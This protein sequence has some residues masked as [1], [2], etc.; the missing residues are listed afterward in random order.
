[1]LARFCI[2]EQCLPDGFRHPFA[3]TML[4]HFAKL[5]ANLRA[6]SR[7][8]TLENQEY[9]FCRLGWRQ[10]KAK[11]LW[12]FWGDDEYVTAGQRK[13][14]DAVEP[15]DEWEELALL[16]GH[17]FLL[18]ARTDDAAQPAQAQPREDWHYKKLE[19][20][21]E[22]VPSA[23]DETN[24]RR[25]GAMFSDGRKAI[26]HGGYGEQSRLDDCDVYS[27]DGAYE[28]KLETGPGNA[29]ALMCHTITS[30]A[31][32]GD[33]FLLA[34]GRQSPGKAIANTWLITSSGHCESANS[35]NDS[36]IFQGRY[37]HSA[38]P[39][40]INGEKDSPG[41]LI[42]GGKS[43]ATTVLGDFVLFDLKKRSW[44]RVPCSS[45]P[46]NRPGPPPR[47]G[48]SMCGAKTLDGSQFGILMGGIS[49][50]GT[51][52]DDVW[53]WTLVWEDGSPRIICRDKAVE[54][55]RFNR[56]LPYARFGAQLIPSV[57]R[58]FLLVGGVTKDRILLW[59]EE[60]LLLPPT[61]RTDFRQVQMQWPPDPRPLFIGMGAVQVQDKTILAGGGAVCFSMGC[62]WN[63][64]SYI[65]QAKHVGDESLDEP[66]FED[67]AGSEAAEA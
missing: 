50:N 40:S 4:N 31:P 8:P 23:G 16:G 36:N 22:P 13:E 6:C 24:Y 26:F 15:F 52:L 32:D 54:I 29:G 59:N 30:V 49:E 67:P 5:H 14:L 65:L 33:L 17:Y 1:M 25:Y 20:T 43:D 12:E 9:R 34:G 19:V 58:S 18:V 62:Y 28:S 39:I 37:R 55:R 56:C 45:A 10:A 2:L 66:A 64:K 35:F 7:Y 60:I 27:G 48:A 47:F 44:F 21:L 63:T 11:T 3:W 53:E 38:V 41:V 51:I 46:E 57:G 61:V 42:Y